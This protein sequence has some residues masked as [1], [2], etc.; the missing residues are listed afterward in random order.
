MVVFMGMAQK[1][2][3]TIGFVM[4]I[5]AAVMWGTFGTFSTFLKGYGLTEGTISLIS[6]LCLLVFFGVF[7]LVR[8]GWRSFIPRVKLLPV[9]VLLGIVEAL[10]SYSTVQAY[11]HLPFA[12][13]S[14]IIYCNLFLLII[15]S[16]I[17]FKMTISWKKILSVIAAIVGIAMVVNIFG[18]HS[19]SNLTGI[20]WAVLAMFCWA[21]LVLCEKYL[22][23]KGMNGNAIIAWEGFLAVIFISIAVCSPVLAV[24]ELVGA[25]DANGMVVL[26]PLAAFGLLTTVLCYWMYIHALNRLE[27]A[28]VQIAYTLDPTTSCLLGFLVFGQTLAPV[29]IAGIALI[30][31]VVIVVQLLDRHDELAKTTQAQAQKQKQK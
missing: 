25:F 15:F 9:I 29:Q 6:P 13:V 30:L 17:I 31:L 20:A 4:A 24:S 3:R 21:A 8:S 7:T 23:E 27:P 18:V 12:M 22:L 28:Y 26:A 2:H 1:S 16:R 11:S 14:T 10:F 19:G 5:T